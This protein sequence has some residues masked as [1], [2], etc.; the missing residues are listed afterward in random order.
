MKRH[1]VLIFLLAALLTAPAWSITVKLGSPF[2][3]LVEFTDFRIAGAGDGGPFGGCGAFGRL[4]FTDLLTQAVEG[5]EDKAEAG[6][7]ELR[8]RLVDQRHHLVHP[9]QRGDDEKAE[10]ERRVEEV[11]H[12]AVAQR[13]LTT[14]VK[15][16]GCRLL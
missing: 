11:D 1:I 13:C 6:A 9:S 4:R 14:V 8:E 7:W 15:M 10:G 16:H 12:A 3:V 2:P 5:A